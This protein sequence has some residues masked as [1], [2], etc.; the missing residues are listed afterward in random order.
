VLQ[1]DATAFKQSRVLKRKIHFKA[2][3][4]SKAHF[5]AA[6]RSKAHF[7]AAL[8]SK[9]HFKAALRSKVHFKAALRSKVN[10]KSSQHAK[11]CTLPHSSFLAGAESGFVEYDVPL[12][13]T[14]RSV[15]HYVCYATALITELTVSVKLLE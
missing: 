10:A 8:R 13:K 14:D 7:M 12:A 9:A 3:L 5:K 6:L 11:Y 2:A 4:R 15:E 1:S